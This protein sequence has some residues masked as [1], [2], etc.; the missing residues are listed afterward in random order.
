MRRAHAVDENQ[1]GLVRALRQLGCSVQSLAGVGNGVPDLAVG[2]KQRNYLFEV[3]DGSKIPSQ[4]KLTPLEV[5]WHRDWRG[6][7]H[8]VWC[9]EDALKILG[10][11]R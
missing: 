8:T 1:A 5:E 7:V 10:L 6:E 11:A 2:W 4:R 3:K 9:L